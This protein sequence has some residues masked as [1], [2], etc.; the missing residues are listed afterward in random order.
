MA[1][2]RE[3]ISLPE[4]SEKELLAP[5]TGLGYTVD[6]RD[7]AAIH[8]LALTNPDAGGERFLLAVGQFPSQPSATVFG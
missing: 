7:V 6:V 2:F 1:L 5:V 4:K 3:Y 8:V